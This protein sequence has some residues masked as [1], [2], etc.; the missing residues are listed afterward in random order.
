MFSKT[1]SHTQIS[2]K[3]SNLALRSTALTPVH[4]ISSC[5][6]TCSPHKHVT[7]TQWTRF[8]F[9]LLHSSSFDCWKGIGQSENAAALLPCAVRK[10]WCCKQTLTPGSRACTS[11]LAPRCADRRLSVTAQVPREGQS[12]HTQGDLLLP[13]ASTTAPEVFAASGMG[14]YINSMGTLRF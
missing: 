7:G 13:T 12:H 14:Q 9:R 5:A 8:M 4:F 6:Y 3:Q 11:D 10:L 1:L 2:M